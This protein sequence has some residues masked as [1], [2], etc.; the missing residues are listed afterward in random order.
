MEELTVTTSWFTT[1]KEM[2]SV[3]SIYD[4]R[5]IGNGCLFQWNLSRNLIN[6][7]DAGENIRRF[8]TKIR[9]TRTKQV[10]ELL[11]EKRHLMNS[12]LPPHVQAPEANIQ[13]SFNKLY[14]VLFYETNLYTEWK[15]KRRLEKSSHR[16]AFLF[17]WSCWLLASLRR[18]HHLFLR[19]E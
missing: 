15:R 9:K 1:L 10:S 5:R 19:V 4:N 3:C 17:V 7:K 2:I 13:R 18:G 6:P 11:V 12:Y 14:S 8:V 16:K